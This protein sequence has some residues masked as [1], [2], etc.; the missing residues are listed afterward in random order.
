M[1]YVETPAAYSGVDSSSLARLCV[2][3][4]SSGLKRLGLQIVRYGDA[5]PTGQDNLPPGYDVEALPTEFFQGDDQVEV[6]GWTVVILPYLESAPLQDVI[7][8]QPQSQSRTNRFKTQ[9]LSDRVN[10]TSRI[11]E[12]RFLNDQLQR[13]F[14]SGQNEGT[15]PMCRTTSSCASRTTQKGMNWAAPRTS[16]R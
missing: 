11:F 9:W 10:V 13:A 3:E 2:C 4:S 6:D 7:Q 8:R 16:P 1:Q 14:Y 12:V 15:P 5:N